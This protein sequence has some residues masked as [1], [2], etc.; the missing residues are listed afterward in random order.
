MLAA[1]LSVLSTAN[2]AEMIRLPLRVHLVQGA[3]FTRTVQF[4]ATGI[5]LP[6]K[7]DVSIK[8][9]G[10]MIAEVNALWAKADIEWVTDTAKNGGGIVT[11]RSGGG[12]LSAAR[13]EQLKAAMWARSR[14]EE[15]DST[16]RD[17]FPA[18]A[19]PNNNETIGPDGQFN[20]AT[21]KMYHL[22]IFPFVGQT[23]QG[24]A[25]TPGTFA[26]VGAYSDKKPN[27]PGIPQARPRY[28]FAGRSALEIAATRFP[29]QGALS[30]TIAHELG[31]NLSLPHNDFGDPENLMKGHVK[32]TLHQAQINQARAQA[33]KGPRLRN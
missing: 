27:T 22:Y 16:M 12:R 4:G 5:P 23:L 24:T 6:V 20:G 2:A 17:V 1:G 18:L 9:A 28:I 7:M 25:F 29:A 15:V 3:D 11:E 31:H 26:I 8:E 19:D 33:T 14:G 32:L 30:A 21:P 13:L 10:L